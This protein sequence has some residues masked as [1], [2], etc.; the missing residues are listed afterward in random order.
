M[1]AT[2]LFNDTISTADISNSEEEH[3]FDADA[4]LLLNITLI[5]CTLLVSICLVLSHVIE[6]I[7]NK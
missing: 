5:F 7:Q 1:G 2:D 4:A 3:Q 6:C